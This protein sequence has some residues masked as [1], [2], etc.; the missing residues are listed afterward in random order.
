MM[1][2]SP[3]LIVRGL[4]NMTETIFEKKC[5]F[6]VPSANMEEGGGF[7][8]ILQPGGNQDALASL[9]WWCHVVHL[10]I[11]TLLHYIWGEETNRSI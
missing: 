6:T 5:L 3:T 4:P 9:L 7:W 10:Y 8:P 1:L 2:D 11:E